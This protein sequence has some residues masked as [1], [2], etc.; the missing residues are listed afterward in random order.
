MFD[1]LFDDALGWTRAT[2]KHKLVWVCVCVCACVCV[3]VCRRASFVA[4]GSEER[5]QYPSFAHGWRN[6]P[7]VW[8]RLFSARTHTMGKRTGRERVCVCVCVCGLVWSTEPFDQWIGTRTT[9]GRGPSVQSGVDSRYV[10]CIRHDSCHL[11]MFKSHAVP[12]A[13]LPPINHTVS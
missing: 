1:L 3:C 4:C 11:R 7:G 12:F 5:S 8:N 9:F 6:K 10:T 13:P 2:G